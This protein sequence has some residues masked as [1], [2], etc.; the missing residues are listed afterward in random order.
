MNYENMQDMEVIKKYSEES[1]NTLSS[2]AS[3]NNR[4]DD[5]TSSSCE[6]KDM[7]TTKHTSNH[8][9][10]KVNIT[11]IT[12]I[13]T[14]SLKS[15]NPPPSNKLN[16]T[17]LVLEMKEKSDI[18]EHHLPQSQLPMIDEECNKIIVEDNG[19]HD[20]LQCDANPCNAEDL[21]FQLAGALLYTD[22]ENTTSI[23]G[24][25]TTSDDDDEDCSESSDYVSGGSSDEENDDNDG[26][27]DTQPSSCETGV[28]EMK[29]EQTSS[30]SE[31]NEQ[32]ELMDGQ[33]NSINE[34]LEQ[35]NSINE[36]VEQGSAPC[37]VDDTDTDEQP[38]EITQFGYF[39]DSLEGR[40]IVEKNSVP[41]DSTIKE[42]TSSDPFITE[43]WIKEIPCSTNKKSPS[44]NT[45]TCENAP[46]SGNGFFYPKDSLKGRN[47]MEKIKK[48][49][50]NKNVKDVFGSFYTVNPD[51]M[52]PHKTNNK[53]PTTE[54][55]ET[56]PLE[57]DYQT[58]NTYLEKIIAD[59]LTMIDDTERDDLCKYMNELDERVSCVP[60]S[61][62][63]DLCNSTNNEVHEN[64][65]ETSPF[66]IDSSSEECFPTLPPSSLNEETEYND[67][68]TL[69]LLLKDKLLNIFFDKIES[70]SC[71]NVA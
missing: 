56:T 1:N 43:E 65:T 34:K 24:V 15:S 5:N 46:V 31:T 71:T 6:E 48:N 62:K 70:L 60:T 3:S 19:I 51:S 21:A 41:I 52:T 8:Y 29:V 32:N 39:P 61:R 69:K 37:F 9:Y 66:T 4:E 44:S 59:S 14:F 18:Q 22:D 13:P 33:G 42:N 30:G 26:S 25:V 49:N 50:D 67:N 2:S 36:E 10:T 68:S 55:N 23:T 28:S 20:K 45:V 58:Y 57:T 38:E 11:P 64:G 12:D 27:Y 17:H 7:C 53:S 63:I 35:N 16:D 54:V 40:H 47:I